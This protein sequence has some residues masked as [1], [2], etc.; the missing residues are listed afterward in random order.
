MKI[1]PDCHATYDDDAE[2]C[3]ADGTALLDAAEVDSEPAAAVPEREVVK[4][5]PNEA[6]SIVDL[7]AMEEQFKARAAEREQEEAAQQAEREQNLAKLDPDATGTLH[8]DDVAAIIGD[9]ST[10]GPMPA[11]ERTQ[12][13]RRPSRTDVIAPPKK[14]PNI[15]VIAGIIA[16]ALFT[17]TILIVVLYF[18]FG[19]SRGPLLTVT[20]VPPEAVVLVDGKDEG[21]APLQTRVKLGT[22]TIELKLDG[23]EPFKE[24]VNVPEDGLQFLQPLKALEGYTPPAPAAA[25]GGAAAEAE[26]ADGGPDAPPAAGDPQVQADLLAGAAQRLID[27]GKYDDA[28]S[29]I[30]DLI[31]IAPDDSRGEDLLD[32]LADAKAGGRASSSG[33]TGRGKHGKR[34]KRDGRRAGRD[35]DDGGD[36]RVRVIAPK[37]PEERKAA[38]KAAYQEGERLFRN[39]QLSQAKRKFQEAIQL[40]SK[41]Y[42]PHRSIA[43]IFQREGNLKK[44][45]YHLGRYLRLGGPDPDLK[46]R[47][48]LEQNAE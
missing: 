14:G 22:H 6:T 18:V 7:E 42:F 36:E 3:A 40:N 23:Y 4:V 33:K 10:T 24:V 44:A 34:G 41:F 45:R 9:Q 43:R 35:D 32:D 12:I 16:G 46:V 39:N 15:A 5:S 48:W 17:L 30:K 13:T 20:S 47:N 25:D 29:K 1:C 21:K 11:A 37:D 28:L 19:P 27:D 31:K 26:P 2:V 8:L 38:A